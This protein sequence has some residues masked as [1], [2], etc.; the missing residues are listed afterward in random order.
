MHYDAL[1]GD[2]GLPFDPINALVSPRP[3]GWI[4]TLSADGVPNLA[5]YSYF[6]L[7]AAKPGVVMFGS[8]SL[9]D[10]Q[11]NVEQTGEFVCNLA[12][13]DLREAVN[14]SSVPAGPE[15]DEFAL[16]GLKTA[17]SRWVRPPRV[18]MAPAALECRYIETVALPTG[19]P[20]QLHKASLI[21]GLVV[22]VYINDANLVEGR[23]DVTRMRP[24]ARLGYMDYS[25][26]DD[27]FIMERAV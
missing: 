23:V 9:K 15:V 25:V 10:S 3:I 2:H 6:N 26:T 1:A 13:W 18:A 19:A 14:R 4:S 8:S 5:P 21:L 24:L 12:T 20:G 11:R 16:T 27:V 17:P 7:V 22:G